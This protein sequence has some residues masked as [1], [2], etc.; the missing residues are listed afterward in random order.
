MADHHRDPDKRAVERRVP[1]ESITN[2][3]KEAL[4]KNT[5]PLPN[6]KRIPRTPNRAGYEKPGRPE[7]G[8]IVAYPRSIA[9]GRAEAARVQ[10]DVEERQGD[11]ERDHDERPQAR[12]DDQATDDERNDR[13]RPN[14]C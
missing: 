11:G 7:N 6:E 5:S 10:A 9:I 8:R 2:G 4:A 13:Q 14:R 1:G 3:Q 12:R